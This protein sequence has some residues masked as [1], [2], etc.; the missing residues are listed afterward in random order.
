MSDTIQTN[1][2]IM[3]DD[4]DT[5]IADDEVLG[6]YISHHPVNRLRLV[7]QA[8]FIYFLAT[9]VLQVLFANLNEQ[10]ASII[11]I[12]LFA[13][14]ALGLAWYLLHLWNRE[15]LIYETGFTYREGSNIA[16]FK[17]EEV[18]SFRQKAERLAYF[19]GLIRRN[20]FAF[21][22]TTYNKESIQMT[23]LYTDIEK[24]G[25]NLERSI[26]KVLRPEIR[27]RLLS[28]EAVAFSD[29][30][31]ITQ[32]GLTVG[33]RQLAW[34]DFAGFNTKGG[35]LTLAS[36]SDSAWYQVALHEVDNL[37]L[38]IELLKQQQPASQTI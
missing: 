32:D 38:L 33:E 27:R 4:E 6:K 37:S 12:F 22:V 8:G 11:L 17:F 3:G 15:V 14:V 18:R 24:L 20:V 16:D 9:T 25:I 19:G 35:K 13:I 29:D 21:T 30:L 1:E 2:P 7:L 10:I 23:N 28:A 5:I 34:K 31:K 26:N 36:P